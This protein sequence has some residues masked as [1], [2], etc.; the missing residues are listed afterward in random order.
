MGVT[1]IILADDHEIFRNGVKELISKEPD[2]EVVGEASDGKAA[3]ELAKSIDADLL[4]M[5]IRM[6]ELN[7]IEASAELLKSNPE[8]RI[9]IFSLYDNKDYVI[10]SLKVGAAGYLLKDTS[11][12]IFLDA[13]RA[14]KNGDFYY[15]GEVS[16]VVIRHFKEHKKND[17]IPDQL[18]KVQLSKR[19][20]EILELIA[21][22]KNSKDTADE[23]GVS[24]RTV[25]AHR[26]NILRKFA[27]NSIEEVLSKM[28]S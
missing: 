26:Q 21:S 15:I 8:A 20:S 28:R 14:V 27:V 24:V 12:K 2:L 7:G 6:P 9:I 16:D 25:D 3:I 23:L 19:E 17:E 22:G 1:K 10:R 18:V 13:I 5:D 11:N 4:I